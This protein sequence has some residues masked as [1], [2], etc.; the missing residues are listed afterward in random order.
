MGAHTSGN[1]LTGLNTNIS[2]EVSKLLRT[3]KKLLIPVC[4]VLLES[5]APSLDGNMPGRHSQS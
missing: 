1:I 5:E 2:R 3:K 4:E